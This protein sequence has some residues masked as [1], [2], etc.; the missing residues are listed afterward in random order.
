MVQWVL[1]YARQQGVA[2]FC[3]GQVWASC[4][5]DQMST[6]GKQVLE[7][8]TEVPMVMA[9]LEHAMPSESAYKPI[10]QILGL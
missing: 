2:T 4:K 7:L 1:R 3:L 6:G 8:S 10:S 9:K 5:D